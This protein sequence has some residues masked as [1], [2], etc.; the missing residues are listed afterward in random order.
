MTGA[1]LIVAPHLDVTAIEG[2]GI[3]V[4][5]DD[6]HRFFAGQAFVTLVSAVE[7]G[8]PA[9]TA[10]GNALDELIAARVLVP[11]GPR[12]EQA[13]WWWR[14]GIEPAGAAARLAGASVSVRAVGSVDEAPVLSA[15]EAVGLAVGGGEPDLEILLT[16]D[17]LDSELDAV[18]RR[19]LETG[20]RWLLAAPQAAEPWIGP[21]FV[22]HRGPCWECLAQRL[23][24]NRAIDTFVSEETGRTARAVRRRGSLPSTVAAASGILAT[25]VAR[26][27]AHGA[28]L[29]DDTVLSVDTGDWTSARHRVVWRPQCPACG[30]P[31][32]SLDAPARAPRLAARGTLP[33]GAGLRATSPAATWE[34]SVHHVSHVSGIVQ[35]LGPVNDV[36][37]PQ[38]VFGTREAPPPRRRDAEWAAPQPGA[39]GGKGTTPDDARV[40]ALGEALERYCGWY[41]GD[42][43]RRFGS[44][45][46]LGEA[47]IHPND[48]LHFSEQQYARREEP[49]REAESTREQVPAPFDP[50]TE[51][52]WS[53]LWS[54]F[55]Q[56]ERLLP[57]AYCYYRAPTPDPML[58]ANSNG[59]AAGNTIEE[60][61]RPRAARAD[62]ARPRRPVVVQPPAPAGHR[63]RLDG[64]GLAGGR[65]Q[66][67]R[68]R[69]SRALGARPYGRPGHPGR[70]RPGALA[71]GSGTGG[72]RVRRRPRRPARDAPGAH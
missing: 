31:A 68:R 55:E 29:G 62:R 13:A 53:P 40:S 51:L 44:L 20:R 52:A 28:L 19:A 47:A 30:E 66:A 32:A 34:R 46:A 50:A 5:E 38:Q 33:A 14:R 27:L 60:A 37:W 7:A 58:G 2:R 16:A 17:Y 15:I 42:E 26:W 61:M 63:P 57:A 1:G 59:C 41:A 18:N 4:V 36:P 67:A 65:L 35:E 23:R 71:R 45:E 64:L 12:D 69:G 39:S 48:C 11:A 10:A 56:R 21:L 3:V 54:L 25:H 72:D 43:P 24:R 9:P 6:V 22:P 49:N 8:E 70:R